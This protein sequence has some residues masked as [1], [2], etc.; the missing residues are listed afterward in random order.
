MRSRFDEQ[1]SIL[2]TELIRM[3]ALCEEAIS[4]ASRAVTHG[5]DAA[6]RVIAVDAEIDRR[7]R[8]IEGLCMKLLLLE[9]PVAHDLRQVSS[10]LKM[11]SDM[12]RIGDQAADIA[13][14][15]PY[16]S[17]VE[18]PETLHIDD[19]ARA[20]VKMVTDSVDSFV[21]NNLDMA[22]QVM[23][24]DDTVDALFDRIKAE[25]TELI[26]GGSFDAEAALDLLMIA[27]YFERIG[28]HA[29]NIAEW[30]EYSITGVRVN[31]EAAL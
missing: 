4:L 21:K 27:K 18:L 5:G 2:N 25:L 11:I 8:D 3:G 14:I 30:V 15:S 10:A 26:R 17:K 1:L 22:R 7:E 12:E 29:V 24:D 13:E 9:H 16:L 19:M 23:C 6:D 28:D 31:N 20:A